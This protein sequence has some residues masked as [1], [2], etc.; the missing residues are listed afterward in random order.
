MYSEQNF[1]PQQLEFEFCQPSIE[2][3]IPKLFDSSAL[4]VLPYRLKRFNFRGKRFYYEFD[5]SQALSLYPSVTTV[6]GATM[7]KGSWYADYILKH[8]SKEAANAYMRERADAGTFLHMMIERLLIEGHLNL[9]ADESEFFDIF[10]E[11]AQS[12]GRN[13]KFVIQYITEI[14]KDLLSF[15]AFCHERELKPI[16]IELTLKSDTLQTAGTLDLYAE[17][18][19]RNKRIRV[20]IDF[21]IGKKG[22]FNSHEAQLHILKGLF[23]ENFPGEKVDMVFNWAGTDWKTEPN[24]KHKD[25]TKSIEAHCYPLYLAIFNTHYADVAS[26]KLPPVIDGEITLG[27]PVD[28]CYYQLTVYEYLLE[29]EKEYGLPL[30]EKVE[31]AKDV[32]GTLFEGL[33]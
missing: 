25:Q 32:Q 15:A 33:E 7:P 5:S 31:E 16:A 13:Y 19:W 2:E 1:Q 12:I 21:K 23:E 22:F 6:C 26:Q 27:Q 3:A 24:G 8:G 17:I 9:L 20:I 28:D 18:T 11:Y 4:R 10:L 30:P 29:R 14:K